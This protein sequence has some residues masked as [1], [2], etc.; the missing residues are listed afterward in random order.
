MLYNDDD[1]AVWP[2]GFWA[3][4]EEVWK[5]DYSYRSDDY[6]VVRRTDHA[7]LIE[8]GAGDAIDPSDVEP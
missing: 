5:G 2:D 1:V 6:E 3:V 7:R 4:L 8:V